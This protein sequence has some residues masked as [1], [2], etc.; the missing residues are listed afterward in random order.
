VSRSSSTEQF[1]GRNAQG[2][3][4]PANQHN[5]CEQGNGKLPSPNLNF[6][7]IGQDPSSKLSS[8]GK[9]Q[10]L[11]P[12]R[13]SCTKG[14][15]RPSG[16]LVVFERNSAY[17]SVDFQLSHCPTAPVLS[18]LSAFHQTAYW[19]LWIGLIY[20]NITRHSSATCRVVETKKDSR[21]LTSS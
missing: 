21:E 8:R 13:H 18:Q 17:R 12:L 10:W 15:V 14:G 7:D 16:E 1:L 19:G 2:P 20:R 11:C 3:A 4:Y 6:Q 5:P 9:G